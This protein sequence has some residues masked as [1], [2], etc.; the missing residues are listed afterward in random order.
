MYADDHQLY[1][2]NQTIEEASMVLEMDGRITGEW[3]KINHLEAN[4]S[5]YQVMMRTKGSGVA[6]GGGGGARG[7][8]PLPPI[9]KKPFSEKG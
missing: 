5:K 1:S 2:L 3:Y 6:K 9:T 4:L 7:G 8:H